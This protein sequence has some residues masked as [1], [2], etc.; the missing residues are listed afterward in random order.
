MVEITPSPV[1]ENCYI[2]TAIDAGYENGLSNKNASPLQEVLQWPN[3]IKRR[4]KTITMNMLCVITYPGKLY[5]KTKK[6]EEVAKLER[7]K[8]GEKGMR[9]QHSR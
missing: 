5:F 2:N 8:T 4:V 1:D 3:T 9:Q 6:K 7:K